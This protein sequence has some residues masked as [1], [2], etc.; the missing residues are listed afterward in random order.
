MGIN[1]HKS[2]SPRDTIYYY[3]IEK[4][5]SSTQYHKFVTN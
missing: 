5:M 3:G 4:L 2:L 1:T